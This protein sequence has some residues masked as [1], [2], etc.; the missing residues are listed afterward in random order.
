MSHIAISESM[1]GKSVDW[2]EKVSKEQYD[3]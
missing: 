1:D 2:I 3:D